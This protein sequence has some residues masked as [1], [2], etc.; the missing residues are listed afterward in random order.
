MINKRGI[1]ITALLLIVAGVLGYLMPAWITGGFLF[2]DGLGAHFVNDIDV[3]EKISPEVMN[4]IEESG[5][6]RINVLIKQSDYDMLAKTGENELKLIKKIKEHDGEAGM[7]ALGYIA[8]N[9]PAD[10]IKWLTKEG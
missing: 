7:G 10:E 6:S 5:E 9:M 1:I 8:V 3:E 4:K 2:V